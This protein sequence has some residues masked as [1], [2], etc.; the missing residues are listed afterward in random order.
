MG[1]Y[2]N[3]SNNAQEW[4]KQ[5][6]YGHY[7]QSRSN[8]FIHLPKYGLPSILEDVNV[9][10]VNIGFNGPGEVWVEED[11]DN[12]AD[13][14]FSNS[15]RKRDF[16]ETNGKWYEYLTALLNPAKSM[17]AIFMINRINPAR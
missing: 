16:R 11:A 12:R 4:L 10:G 6:E 17:I 2:I 7:L 13:A 8:G 1:A 15:Y 14:F 9:F 5:H 3:V